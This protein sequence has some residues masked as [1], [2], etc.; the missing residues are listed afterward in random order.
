MAAAFLREKDY[1]LIIAVRSGE[2][3]KK[4]RAHEV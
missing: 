3:K 4:E 1:G 2:C